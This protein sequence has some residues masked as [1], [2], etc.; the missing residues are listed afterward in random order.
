MEQSALAFDNQAAI[1]RKLIRDIAVKY[2]IEDNCKILLT[3]IAKYSKDH[4]KGS[5]VTEISNYS[6]LS[7][8]HL[9]S[10]NSSCPSLRMI[11]LIMFTVIYCD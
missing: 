9:I 4:V 6:S 7:E 11:I 10:G 5:L 1:E 3:K 2:C 8:F